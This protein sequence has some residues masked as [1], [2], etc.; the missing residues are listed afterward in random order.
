MRRVLFPFLAVLVGVALPYFAVEGIYSVA[1]G[2]RATTSLTYDLFRR[3]IVDR[4]ASS[5]DPHDPTTQVI[6]EPSQFKAMLGLFKENGVAIGNSPFWGLK[7]D[8][9]AINTEEDGCKT[10][11]PGLRKTMAFL[12]S[13]VFN[14]FDQLTY[15]YDSDRHL[16]SRLEAFFRRYG[17]RR[18][19][20]STNPHG[21]RITLPIVS[22]NDKILVAG[23]SVANGVMLD[24]TETIASQLQA[25]DPAHQYINLG[26]SGAGASDIQCALDKAAK[27][28]A[29]QIREVIYML[30]ENDFETAT[31]KEMVDWLDRFRKE[32]DIGRVV[33]VYVPFVYNVVPEVTRIIGHTHYNFPTFREEKAELLTAARQAGFT[34][35][36]YIDI[37]L[38]EQRAVGSQFGPLALYLDHTHLSIRG[39]E[40]LVP[41]LGAATRPGV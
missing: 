1:R 11:K 38:A 36:D 9:V 12:K 18:V 33:L 4:R 26:I 40:R 29:G 32:H 28:Y 24:D 19:N 30:C 37:T 16:P 35:I 39:V 3:W 8:A 41:I 34:V 5:Y 14:P 6:A 22:S 15:F 2:P 25:R 10:Q 20:L 17:F 21:E 23:D 31:P 13:N 7:N 27:R